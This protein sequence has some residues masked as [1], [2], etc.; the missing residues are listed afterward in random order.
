MSNVINWNER[1]KRQRTGPPLTY[2]EEFVATD[3]WYVKEL[4]SDVPAEELH[5]A[6]EDENFK[7]DGDED[8]E[9]VEEEEEEESED[10]TY[11]EGGEEEEEDATDTSDEGGDDEDDD[12][13]NCDLEGDSDSGTLYPEGWESSGEGE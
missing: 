9:E 13:L 11:S 6:L 7:E 12:P 1:S 3:E 10:P 5:A 8:E 4:L 2:W